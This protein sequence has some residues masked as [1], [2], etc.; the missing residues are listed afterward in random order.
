MHIAIIASSFGLFVLLL[1]VGLIE[2]TTS[3]NAATLPSSLDGFVTYSPV[4]LAVSTL[5]AISIGVIDVISNR[6]NG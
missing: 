6:G 1:V 5:A 3:L 2:F 4:L